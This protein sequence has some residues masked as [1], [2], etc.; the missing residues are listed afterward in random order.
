[1]KKKIVQKKKRKEK[2]KN[3]NKLVTCRNK[4]F[5]IKKFFLDTKLVIFSF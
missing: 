3:L 4:I 1:M 2:K 5:L